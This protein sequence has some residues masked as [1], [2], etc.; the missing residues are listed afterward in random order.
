VTLALQPKALFG[1]VTADIIVKPDV[2]AT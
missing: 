2:K 1:T